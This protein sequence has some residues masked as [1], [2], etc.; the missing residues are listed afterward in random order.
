MLRDH[1]VLHLPNIYIQGQTFPH[2]RPIFSSTTKMPA[3]QATIEYLED[4]PLY[5]TEKPYWCLLP[6]H[7]DFD[8]NKHRVDNL[9][10]ELRP[11][12]TISDI[13]DAKEDL[14][15]ETSGFQV[16]SHHSECSALPQTVEDV[17]AYKTETEIMLKENLNAAF[18][19]CY[20]LRARKNVIFQREQFDINDPLLVEGPARGAHNGI[21][22][23]YYRYFISPILIAALWFRQVTQSTAYGEHCIRGAEVRRALGHCNDCGGRLRPPVTSLFS[24]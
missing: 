24:R 9:E 19:K 17:S 15:L 7:E 5:E 2:F 1:G 23:S 14:T 21:I 4:L 12:I 3:V 6:P 11:N 18:V 10:F 8:P 20:E 22:S 13:R 16:L